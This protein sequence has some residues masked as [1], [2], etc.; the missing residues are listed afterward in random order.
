MGGTGKSQYL[1]LAVVLG[2]LSV[3][4]SEN[5]FWVV[6]PEGLDFGELALTVAA[7]A[8]AAGVAL[9]AVIW[10]G[11]GGLSGAFLGGCLMGLMS[12]GVIVGTIYEGFPLQ[13]V[14]TPLAWHGVITG[15]V[16]LGLG[17]QPKW[18]IWAGLGLAGAYW[19][20]YWPSERGLPGL[21]MF[22]AYILGF[23]LV[24]P[25][26]HL[27]MDR[28]GVLPRPAAWVLLV[29]P[30]IA[31]FVWVAQTMADP[32]PLRLALPVMLVWILWVMR[33]LGRGAEVALGTGA[34]GRHL[35]FLLAPALMVGLAPLGWSMG[36][37]T[38]EANWVVA[39]ASSLVAVVW[40][41]RL[42]WAAVSV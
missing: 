24:V 33:R 31:A 15:G 26:A 10:S 7:Y 38:M 11:M 32:N 29:A 35:M 37:G 5:W 20:Q 2:A 16:V 1:A 41:G 22:A 14:W 12:E 19:A 18:W 34:P 13:L 36:W 30:G 17:R 3:W 21:G 28:V 8:V 40:L 27:V 4:A 39:L 23:G 42:T 9:S 25:L 6:P